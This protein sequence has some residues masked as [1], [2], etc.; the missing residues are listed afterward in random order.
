M[1]SARLEGMKKNQLRYQ[2]VPW[3]MIQSTCLRPSPRFSSR[4]NMS[5][6]SMN[7]VT[8]AHPSARPYFKNSSIA[9]TEPEQG[10][11]RKVEEDIDLGIEITTKQRQPSKLQQLQQV[12]EERQSMSSIFEN[13]QRSSYVFKAQV[14]PIPESDSVVSIAQLDR[15]LEEEEVAAPNYKLTKDQSMVIASGPVTIQDIKEHVLIY[16]RETNP[17]DESG[18]IKNFD[19]TVSNEKGR[20]LATPIANGGKRKV[21]R[22]IKQYSSVQRESDDL[23]RA[24]R[25]NSTKHG[26]LLKI[27]HRKELERSYSAFKYS[28]Y[29]YKNNLKPSEFIEDLDFHKVQQQKIQEKQT[30]K[31]KGWSAVMISKARAGGFTSKS[32]SP[33]TD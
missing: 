10:I 14:Q 26:A 9:F 28:R 8:S 2:N 30:M 20:T 6:R 18:R 1:T 33:A 31:S 13:T 5:S 12:N 32:E 11:I 7:S 23:E 16:A 17:P 19:V 22:T 24:I 29:V 4:S 25:G 15:P 27:K 21:Q 3:I